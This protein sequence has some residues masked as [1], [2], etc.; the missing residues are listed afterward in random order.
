[1]NQSSSNITESMSMAENVSSSAVLID[2]SSNPRV[3][4]R[5]S[6]SSTGSPNKLARWSLKCCCCSRPMVVCLSLCLILVIMCVV[7]TVHFTSKP[8]PLLQ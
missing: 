8:S 1:M 4:I 7:F 3:T 2:S 6:S 5:T